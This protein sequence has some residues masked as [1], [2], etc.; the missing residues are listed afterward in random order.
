ME[1]SD[2]PVT[3]VLIKIINH[4]NNGTVRIKT[5]LMTMKV[6]IVISFQYMDCGG[7]CNRQS[8]DGRMLHYCRVVLQWQT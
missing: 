4:N 5:Y 7:E 6:N 2:A 1:I 8:T 3:S